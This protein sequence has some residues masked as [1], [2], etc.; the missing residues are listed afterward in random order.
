M[1]RGEDLWRRFEGL[2]EENIRDVNLFDCLPSSMAGYH[3]HACDTRSDTG[4]SCPY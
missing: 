4:G 1:N 3:G 2:E